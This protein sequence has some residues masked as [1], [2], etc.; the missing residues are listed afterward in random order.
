MLFIFCIKAKM[1]GDRLKNI[2][3]SL[4][5]SQKNLADMLN[6]KAPALSR[7]ESGDV[8]PTMDVLKFFSNGFNIN[9]H[10]ILTGKGSMFLNATES[11]EC[12]NCQELKKENNDLKQEVKNLEGTIR[13]LENVLVRV[14]QKSKPEKEYP[15]K[16]NTG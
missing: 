7:Y 16:K 8:I 15:V 3:D 6:I 13:T 5:I 11:G 4:N 10:W 14:V 1:I 12:P 9:L 2:R